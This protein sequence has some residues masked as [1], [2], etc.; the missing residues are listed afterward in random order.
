MANSLG[1][2]RR[3]RTNAPPLALLLRRAR[4]QLGLEQRALAK[5][6][7]I[8]P[9]TLS[10]WEAGGARPVR[11]CREL[12]AKVL[13]NID[14]ETW[15]AIV[16]ELGLPLDQMLAKNAIQRAK[17]PPPPPPPEPPPPEPEPPPA[18]PAPT[19]AQI[20]AALDDLVRAT[21]E[22][23]DVTARRLRAA[24][25]NV[26]ADLAALGLSPAEAREHVMHRAAR[27]SK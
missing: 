21:A 1:H 24:L 22:D 23:L 25:G 10:R 3:Q 11:D 8:T 9:R 26:L 19:S 2:M 13:E 27:A 4:T 5:H 12:V 18:P 7:Q 6:F 16:T 20:R 17:L 14:G 15:R